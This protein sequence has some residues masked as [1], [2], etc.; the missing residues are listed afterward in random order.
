VEVE[1]IIPSEGEMHVSSVSETTVAS[2]AAAPKPSLSK[3][4]EMLPAAKKFVPVTVSKVPPPILPKLGF[5]AEME[6]GLKYS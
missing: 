5:T 4:Q 2:L 1:V 3:P 6:D